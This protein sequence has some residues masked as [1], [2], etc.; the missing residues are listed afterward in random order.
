MYRLSKNSYVVLAWVT[1]VTVQGFP[2]EKVP[3]ICGLKEA[4]TEVVSGMDKKED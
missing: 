3:T 2:L 4:V 1:A